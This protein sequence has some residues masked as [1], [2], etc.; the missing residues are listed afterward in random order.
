MKTL[1]RLEG[2]FCHPNNISSD[3]FYHDIY[4]K[5]CDVKVTKPIA[6]CTIFGKKKSIYLHDIENFFNDN[7]DY[8]LC[9]EGSICVR[10]TEKQLDKLVFNNFDENDIDI[11]ELIEVNIKGHI[12]EFYPVRWL[13]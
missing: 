3:I 6:S 12:L 13:Y 2:A 5:I 9:F 10:L 11:P 4:K 7:F 1:L 8:G